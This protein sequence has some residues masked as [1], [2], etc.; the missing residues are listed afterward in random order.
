MEHDPLCF[1]NTAAQTRLTQCSYT[2]SRGFFF[3]SFSFCQEENI[4][5][6]TEPSSSNTRWEA[7]HEAKGVVKME[8][9]GEQKKT[10]QKKH[11][12]TPFSVFTFCFYVKHIL[13]IW[14]ISISVFCCNVSFKEMHFYQSNSTT[15]WR[16][17][18]HYVYIEWSQHECDGHWTANF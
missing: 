10:K 4:P 16:S 12:Y 17:P 1:R 2:G 11:R 7:E 8:A 15:I 14:H 13:G 6:S 3:S 9:E 5:L 18:L